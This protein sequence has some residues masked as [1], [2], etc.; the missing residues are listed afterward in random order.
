MKSV[1]RAVPSEVTQARREL[2]CRPPFP[3]HPVV[4]RT[5]RVCCGNT[6]TQAVVC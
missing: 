1:S 2:Q 5:A 3:Q 4:A 6:Y